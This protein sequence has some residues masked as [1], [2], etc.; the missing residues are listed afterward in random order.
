M[1]WDPLQGGIGVDE[2]GR[3]CR[4]PR[5]DVRLLPREG[6]KLATRF[7]E[8]FGRGVEADDTGFGKGVGENAGQVARAAAEVVDGGV[9]AFGDAGHEIEARAKADVGVA[10]VSL[11]F[12]GSHS[13]EKKSYHCYSKGCGRTKIRRESPA[14]D[15]AAPFRGGPRRRFCASCDTDDS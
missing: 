9:F 1:V 10:E 3:S 5:A 14:C 2:I 6:G 4:V 13:G 11:R 8:H 15:R 12:P 7:G